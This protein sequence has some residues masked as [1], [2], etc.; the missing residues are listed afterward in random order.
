MRAMT[1][2]LLP[3]VLLLA[4]F[5][6]LAARSAAR[7]PAPEPAAAPILH[8]HRIAREFRDTCAW[9]NATVIDDVHL[10]GLLDT[11]LAVDLNLCICLSFLPELLTGDIQLITLGG[12]LGIDNLEVELTAVVRPVYAMMGGDR[13][14]ITG[15]GCG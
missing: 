11:D 6:A 8:Q 9:V 3:F 15:A 12:L 2:A 4:S 14:E 10:G 13:V 5:P 7:A 1:T